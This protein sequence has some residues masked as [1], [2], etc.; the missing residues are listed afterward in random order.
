MESFHEHIDRLLEQGKLSAASHCQYERLSGDGSDRVFIRIAL[1]TGASCLAVFPSPTLS[2]G[3]A[4][5][6]ANSAYS[7]N[8]HL[9]SKGVAVPRVF[10]YDSVSGGI[11]F[12]YLGNTLLYDI[13]KK[14]ISDPVEWYKKAL[15]NLVTFQAKGVSGFKDSYCWDTPNY[16]R[17]LMLSRESGYFLR[18]FCVDHVGLKAI[19]VDLQDDFNRL[20]DRITKEGCR[21]LLHR[22]YQSRNLMVTDKDLYIIDFQGARFGPLGYDVASLLNDPYVNLDAG[23]KKMLFEYYLDVLA[24]Q[25]SVDRG[26]FVDGYYHIALQRN[27]QVLGAYAFLGYKKNKV[28]FRDFIA[29]AF[30]NLSSLVHGEL[31]GTYPALEELIKEIAGKVSTQL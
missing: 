14:K 16:D 19:S 20:A 13:V 31:S 12:E 26:H 25:T 30:S 29:P 1:D 2:A 6:E 7:I 15:E 10:A 23:L 28:F 9:E 3:N 4:L 11:L 8:K 22:D 17:Q 18:E 24:Q 21:F 27:L 5:A